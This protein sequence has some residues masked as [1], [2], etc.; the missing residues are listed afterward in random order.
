MRPEGG[1]KKRPMAGNKIKAKRTCL[2][3]RI[4]PPYW[5]R[6]ERGTALLAY[7]L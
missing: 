7:L 6:T 5:N 3:V 2:H 1:R 4:V